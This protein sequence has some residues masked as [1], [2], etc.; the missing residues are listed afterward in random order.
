[1]NTGISHAYGSERRPRGRARPGSSR[2]FRRYRWLVISGW[3]LIVLAIGWV[4]IFRSE[5]APVAAALP[6]A[7]ERPQA[8]G[9]SASAMPP[10]SLPADDAPHAVLTEWWYY[11]GHLQ[12]A[13][14]ERFSF[15]L[16]TFLR[17][18]T[19]THTVFHGSLL[20]HRNG[21]LYSEQSRTAGNP[22]HGRKDGFEFSHGPWQMRG[23]GSRHVARMAGKGFAL[24][25]ML[26][27]QLPPVLH[28]APGTP[29]EGL[30]DFGAAGL[31]YYTSRPRMAAEGTLTIEG[32]VMPVTGDV[33]FDHQWGDF[34]AAQLRW[35]WFALQLADGADIMLF[36]LFDRQGAP[37]LRMGTHAKGGVVTALGP[38]DFTT[39]SHGTWT[40]PASGVV[41]PVDWTILL[42]AWG[43]RLKIEPAFRASEMDARTTTLNVYWEGAVKVGGSHAGRGFMELS[44]YSPTAEQGGKGGKSS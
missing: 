40:S 27:D 38:R 1:M 36:E 12:T 9:K 4:L 29:Q 43:A 42:P 17:Q 20:D 44:G 32:K 14:G 10:V 11:S 30:L 6:P 2:W 35:N 19:L 16:A 26:N 33:W 13:S 41:Y 37:V 21:R 8:T 3:L 39:T 22:S 7:S 15:H 25:L 23:E 5:K 24:D 31:S 18:G 28:Q 34:E